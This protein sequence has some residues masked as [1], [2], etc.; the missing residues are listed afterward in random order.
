MI[1]TSRIPIF[2]ARR[3]ADNIFRVVVGLSTVSAQKIVV[4]MDFIVET[5]ILHNSW[6]P[7]KGSFDRFL[8]LCFFHRRGRVDARDV[9]VG[10]PALYL[11]E[12]I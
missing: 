4:L 1:I 2:Y 11:A 5:T 3:C 7:Y 9:E 10:V 6:G 12:K 8:V